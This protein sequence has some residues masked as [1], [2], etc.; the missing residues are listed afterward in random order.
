MELTNYLDNI[1]DLS[2]ISDGVMIVDTQ[3]TIVR[4]D[5]FNASFKQIDAQAAVG[6]NLL[7]VYPGLN[8]NTSLLFRALSGTSTIG[9][10]TEEVWYDGTV[11]NLIE[12]DYPIKRNGE[13]IGAIN[14]SHYANSLF[15]NDNTAATRPRLYTIQDILGSSAQ[16]TEHIREILR[17][18][19]TNSSVFIYGETGTGKEL[20]AQSIHMSGSR[21]NC[22]FLV[23]NCA[24]IP[25]T[26]LESI[27]FGTVSGSF[28]G[29][30]NR[31]GIFEKAH[32]GTLFLDEINSMNKGL[33]SKLLRVLEDHKVTRL[34]DTK[35]RL[36]DVRVIA[37]TN[38][39]PKACLED[40]DLRSDL[41]YRLNAVSLRIP[42]L[43][44]RREDIP[45][46]CQHFIDRF[47][48]EMGKQVTGLD[49]DVEDYLFSYDYP[50]NIRELRNIIESM[51]NKSPG[52]QLSLEDLPYYMIREDSDSPGSTG[53]NNAALRVSA[54]LSDQIDSNHFS[55]LKDAV[56]RFEVQYILD[57][58]HDVST[59][60]GLAKKLG[61]TPQSL[62]YKLNKYDLKKQI[63]LK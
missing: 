25:A 45:Q 18:A 12:S 46:L 35:E 47:N 36:V 15:P 28:T 51:M 59:Y 17:I 8:R 3:G 43:R 61:I 13:I 22:P 53:R 62:Q 19:D 31:P 5:H 41:Y 6:K 42:P 39:D 55:T 4:F 60:A 2:L 34:G 44:E 11:V 10:F 52:K 29:A 33:Q 38:K 56:D 32:H 27:F 57:A 1:P 50:G 40:G 54:S 63:T 49:K 16:V 9:A 26:L 30:E 24:A 48:R 20:A 21:R 23:Q 58:C 14:I 7:D 37:S